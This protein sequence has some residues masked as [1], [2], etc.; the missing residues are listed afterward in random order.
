MREYR[1]VLSVQDVCFIFRSIKQAPIIFEL[2][3]DIS[4]F[5]ALTLYVRC[6]R[7]F[8]IFN[9]AALFSCVS[10]GSLYTKG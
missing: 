6:V 2:L 8:Y 1:L 3:F 7:I 9:I 10:S 4:R 5:L